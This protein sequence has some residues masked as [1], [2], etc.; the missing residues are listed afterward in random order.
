MEKKTSRL[1]W[2]LLISAVVILLDRIS[3]NWVSQHIELGH[4]IPVIPKVFRIT[5]VLQRR[6]SLLPLRRFRHPGA[7]PLGPESPLSAWRHS[8]F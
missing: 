8:R 1:P 7:R 6:R 5:H 4:A 2:L 3:K